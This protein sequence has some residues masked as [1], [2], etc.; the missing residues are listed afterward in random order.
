MGLQ[1]QEPLLEMPGLDTPQ[2]GA[3]TGCRDSRVQ[4]PL[5]NTGPGPGALGVWPEKAHPTLTFQA[6]QSLG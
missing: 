5:G 3:D 6:G 4:N 1:G 2:Q